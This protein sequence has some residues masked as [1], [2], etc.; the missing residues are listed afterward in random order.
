V[1]A[2]ARDAAESVQGAR[3]LED[4]RLW[5]IV[6]AA[7]AF[8]AGLAAG[9]FLVARPAPT[10][11]A[12]NDGF[13]DYARLMVERFQLS[14]K[15]RELL[16]VVL[17]EYQAD[18]DELRARHAARLAQ[19]MEPELRELGLRYRAIVRDKVLPVS[20]REE[21]DRLAMNAR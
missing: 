2:D 10:T 5:I 3:R 18:L 12:S 19:D 6:L 4:L 9:A 7:T 16:S 1:S 11:A 15:R 20:G 21:F 17:E 13:E 14:D 8:G